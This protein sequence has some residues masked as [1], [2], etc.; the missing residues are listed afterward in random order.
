MSLVG[1]T[2]KLRANMDPCAPWA[3]HWL[4]LSSTPLAPII[5]PYWGSKSRLSHFNC[6]VGDR[7]KCHRL[8]VKWCNEQSYIFRQCPKWVK[9]I[10]HSMCG[11][12]AAW[13]PLSWWTCCQ[14][15]QVKKVK[16]HRYDEDHFTDS[17]PFQRHQNF[18]NMDKESVRCPVSVWASSWLRGQ[19]HELCILFYICILFFRFV[20]KSDKQF[21]ASCSPVGLAPT[22][23]VWVILAQPVSEQNLSVCITWP[24]RVIAMVWW[25][26]QMT[27]ETF[28]P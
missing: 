15:F 17:N 7:L 4:R 23:D 16:S 25:E 5:T 28:T 27:L 14:L 18:V 8:V 1:R 12:R 20:E 11:R 6:A 26:L 22:P 3:I 9:Q 24:K 21:C 2:P 10:E 19:Q 13:S